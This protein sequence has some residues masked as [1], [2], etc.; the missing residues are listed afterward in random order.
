[1]NITAVIPSRYGSSRFRGKP[2]AHIVG[3]PMIQRVY[4]L[5]KEADSITDVIVATDDYRIVE[6]VENFGGR[7]VM[8]SSE[9]RTGSDRVAET[10]DLI[11]LHPDDIIVNIQGDQPLFNPC[12]L[13]ELVK[14]FLSDQDFE[15][16]TLAYKIVN[17]KEIIDPKNVKVT[18]DKNGFALYFSRSTIPCGYNE[19]NG[20]D[21]YKH[22]GFYGYKKS[23]LD[24]FKSLPAGDLEKIEKLEQLRV[25]E[26]GHKIKVVVT[27]FD[28]PS[29]DLPEDIVRIERVIHTKFR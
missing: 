27:E 15:M 2:L 13:D 14:P 4:E 25:L 16:S 9:N 28:S 22:L 11:G 7:A 26:H 20:F 24:L 29:V 18:F 17:Q 12:C 3:K 10:A 21:I 23:F 6:T 8:T 5:A 19:P 1:M